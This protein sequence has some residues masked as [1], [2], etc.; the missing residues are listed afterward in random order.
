MEQE[1]SLRP[2]PTPPHHPRSPKNHTGHTPQQ[3]WTCRHPENP[4]AQSPVRPRQRHL[5]AGRAL[6]AGA[7]QTRSPVR[8]NR[9]RHLRG[10]SFLASRPTPRGPDVRQRIAPR[11]CRKSR[12]NLHQETRQP[13][14]LAGRR[15]R[16]VNRHKESRRTRERSREMWPTPSTVSVRQRGLNQAEGEGQGEP[17]RPQVATHKL[18]AIRTKVPRTQP[19]S[20]LTRTLTRK[21]VPMPSPIPGCLRHRSD[22]AIDHKARLLIGF[23]STPLRFRFQDTSPGTFIRDACFDRN[24]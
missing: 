22:V 23:L 21:H 2:P 20:S 17:H 14:S 16:R 19:S 9:C 10:C 8:S 5:H 6:H 13:A 4:P 1:S 7:K 24:Q 18:H 3:W 11:R 15:P 12:N